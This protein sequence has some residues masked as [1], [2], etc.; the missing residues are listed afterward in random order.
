MPLL[1]SV[2]HCPSSPAF[3]PL[4]FHLLFFLSPLIFPLL[5]FS[6][7]FFL[8]HFLPHSCTLLLP[9]L[10][11]FRAEFPPTPHLVLPR[12]PNFFSHSDPFPFWA[13]HP[14]P[15]VECLL[16]G[17]QVMEKRILIYKVYESLAV[18]SKVGPLPKKFLAFF[19]GL[20]ISKIKWCFYFLKLLTKK[21]LSIGEIHIISQSM[22]SIEGYLHA[23]VHSEHW[24]CCAKGCHIPAFRERKV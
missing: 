6:S 3:S 24:G 2:H 15:D 13:K 10:S 21:N 20:H 22:M 4:S 17:W 12:G 19:A 11:F 5:D 18:S 1:C 8:C 7:P 9:L 14:P 23:G 16:P